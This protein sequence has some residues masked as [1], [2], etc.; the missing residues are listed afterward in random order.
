VIWS[1]CDLSKSIKKGLSKILS[2]LILLFIC[3]T[4]SNIKSLSASFQTYIN[5]YS[6]TYSL[7]L[8]VVNN[9]WNV[10]TVS[11]HLVNIADE[12]RVV[13][14]ARVADFVSIDKL[15]DFI[16]GQFEVKCAQTC[17][18]LLNSVSTKM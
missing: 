18:E 15:G 1:Y 11:E 9:I 4:A 16:L 8:N 7:R 5:H 12:G 10:N 2:A 3:V 14:K 13:D 17:T 6:N